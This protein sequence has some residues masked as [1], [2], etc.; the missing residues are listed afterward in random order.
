MSLRRNRG[1]E[2]SGEL[3]RIE[4]RAYE[5]AFRV[6][7]EVAVEKVMATACEWSAQP[8]RFN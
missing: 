5:K 8:R 6:Y 3:K 7:E 4:T 1:W 2:K